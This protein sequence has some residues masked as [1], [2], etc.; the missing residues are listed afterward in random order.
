MQV[1][2]NRLK[3]LGLVSFSDCARQS[4]QLATVKLRGRRNQQHNIVTNLLHSPYTSD[5][6]KELDAQIPFV[7]PSANS[8]LSH[9]FSLLNTA[10]N[11]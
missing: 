11:C 1:S 7:L 4:D 9:S 10:N 3:N 5:V 6:L 2:K 8:L